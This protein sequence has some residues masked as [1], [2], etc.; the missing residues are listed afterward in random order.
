MRLFR[1]GLGFASNGC[2]WLIDDRLVDS[3]LQRSLPTAVA[4]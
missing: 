4:L 3:F 2:E 1:N